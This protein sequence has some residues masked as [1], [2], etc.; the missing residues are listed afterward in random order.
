MHNLTLQ[1]HEGWQTTGLFA[2]P[3]EPLAICFDKS[4][5]PAAA[6]WG[7]E[8]CTDEPCMWEARIGCHTDTLWHKEEMLR[9][10]DMRCTA[11]LTQPLTVMVSPYGGPLYLELKPGR[12]ARWPDSGMGTAA[13]SVT[14]AITAP[15][16]RHG[17]TAADW[18]DARAQPAPFAEL[19]GDHI[20]FSLPSFSIRSLN[21][22]RIRRTLQFWDKIIGA[23]CELAGITVPARPERVVC[24]VQISAGYMHSGYPVMVH[25]DQVDPA[26]CAADSPP[27]VDIEA[28][29]ARGSWGMYHELG[30][31]R[32]L[33]AYT[34]SGTTEVTV[35]IFTLF[36]MHRINHVGEPN[37]AP[38]AP[39]RL[40]CLA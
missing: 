1:P 23:H 33:G 18:S 25:L 5:A 40:R 15:V 39:P 21:F 7:D 9:W 4:E 3:G 32:Q 22:D 10:P 17:M 13:V 12:S 8:S 26:K 30:H 29:E 11:A 6:M 28:L 35:N 16:F 24:D 37:H 20:I 31:N 19:A 2:L 36:T 14:G 27:V 38:A 34:F